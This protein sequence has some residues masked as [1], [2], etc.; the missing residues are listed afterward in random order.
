M[1]RRYYVFL[2][3][4]VMFVGISLYFMTRNLKKA[5]ASRC[6]Y[7]S[8]LTMIYSREG[9][10]ETCAWLNDNGD[11]T[12]AEDKK[13]AYEIRKYNDENHVVREDYYDE[14]G[15]L[16]YLQAGYCSFE[17]D[18]DW[19]VITYRYLDE[20]NKL[21]ERTEKYSI[22]VRTFESKEAK[23][24]TDRY[25]DREMKPVSVYG[26][27]GTSY[28]YHGDRQ[29]GYTYL[30]EN[31]KP[32]ELSSGYASAKRTFYDDNKTK[33][34]MY[35]DANGE[36]VCTS[37]GHYGISIE[38]YDNG[39]RSSI[40]SLDINALPMENSKGYVSVKYIYRDNG[41]LQ[42]ELYLD[43]NGL[44]CK[45]KDG[46]Y[47]KYHSGEIE[48]YLNRF[49]LKYMSIDSLLNQ[50]PYIVVIA[51]FILCIL[52]IVLP[53]KCRI[54]LLPMYCIF[55]LFKTILSRET[56]DLDLNLNPWNSYKDTITNVNTAL[57]VINN[58]WLFVPYG[59]GI[60]SIFK[61]KKVLICLLMLPIVVELIQLVFRVGTFETADIINNM[62][63]EL[64]G[65]AIYMCWKSLKSNKSERSEQRQN[66]S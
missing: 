54:V 57:E 22:L 2:V 33:T 17:I 63:G 51:A 49:G 65:I 14:H 43:A 38:Y 45:G 3:F 39:K 37:D 35:L 24:F 50:Y 66:Q 21:V 8:E 4:L 16:S 11:I 5:Y 60:K 20:N 28:I 13:Y 29:L 42:K 15:K 1:K 52:F 7:S 12:W 58:I 23:D 56:R 25:F 9:N 6:F 34:E 19:P 27:Y 26:R 55:I 46:S 44:P 10:T 32:I 18:E 36:A 40:T 53:K 48:L 41:T 64:I 47:G 31:D 30:D 62:L 61:N 59:I